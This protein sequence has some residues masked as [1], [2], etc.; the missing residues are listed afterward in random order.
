[1]NGFEIIGEVNGSE[2][3]DALLFV[4]RLSLPSS[5]VSWDGAANWQSA[6]TLLNRNHRLRHLAMVRQPKPDA[7]A[8]LFALAAAAGGVVIVTFIVDLLLLLLL[9]Q[10]QLS[11]LHLGVR[12]ENCDIQQSH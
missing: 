1:M 7:A 2:V 12:L 5:S 3:V 9:L 10:E 11:S 4:L 8:S 6:S